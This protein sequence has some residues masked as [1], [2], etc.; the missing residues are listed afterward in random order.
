MDSGST[1]APNTTTWVGEVYGEYV[2]MRSTPDLNTQ[3]NILG[4]YP[5]G[6]RVTILAQTSNGFYQVTVN[7]ITGYMHK[8]YVKIV[9]ETEAA[10]TA[11]ATTTANVYLRAKASSTGSVLTTIPK[12]A[13]LT[14]LGSSGDYYQAQYGSLSGYLVKKYVSVR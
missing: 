12:G 7:G 8:D 14:I 13:T 6:T 9:G 1:T 10:S 4:D 11:S 2:R 5:V 3:S